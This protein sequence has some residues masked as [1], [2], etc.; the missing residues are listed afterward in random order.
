[1][2]DEARRR[3]EVLRKVAF[4]GGEGEGGKLR[5]GEARVKAGKGEGEGEVSPDLSESPLERG[6]AVSPMGSLSR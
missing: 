3:Q 4:G 5:P 2:M 1:M 6:F